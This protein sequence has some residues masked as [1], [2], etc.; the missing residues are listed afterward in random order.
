MSKCSVCNTK[1]NIACCTIYHSSLVT[2][3]L[4]LC[5]GCDTC[6]LPFQCL[7][8]TTHPFLI[9]LIPGIW[10]GRFPLPEKK[11]NVMKYMYSYTSSK[12]P[13]HKVISINY[14]SLNW[15]IQF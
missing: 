12:L 10:C 11:E 13:N 1:I 14:L 4:P 3:D 6:T 7:S 5:E 8:W 2:K 9:S 15:L